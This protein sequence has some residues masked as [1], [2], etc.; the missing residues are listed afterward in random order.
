M[1]AIID[2][3]SYTDEISHSYQLSD[4]NLTNKGNHSMNLKRYYSLV[5]MDSQEFNK[6]HLRSNAFS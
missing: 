6:L 1:D 4:L 5:L 3:Q 2:A